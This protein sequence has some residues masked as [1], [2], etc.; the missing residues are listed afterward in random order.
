MNVEWY[1]YHVKPIL[2]FNERGGILVAMNGSIY[3]TYDY[4]KE[5]NECLSEDYCGPISLSDPRVDGWCFVK[6]IYPR[7]VKI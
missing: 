7:G 5:T 4:D 6:D 1:S 2:D 3:T